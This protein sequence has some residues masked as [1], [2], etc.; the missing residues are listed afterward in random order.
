M[1]RR[2]KLTRVVSIFRSYYRVQAL[3]QLVKNIVVY[4]P[5]AKVKNFLPKLKMYF[6]TLL[7]IRLKEHHKQLN[8]LS[9]IDLNLLK[10]MLAIYLRRVSNRTIKISDR[11]SFKFE[12]IDLNAVLQKQ[13]I[14][15]RDLIAEQKQELQKQAKE[16]LDQERRVLESRIKDN[17]RS[18]QRK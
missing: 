17:Y 12:K 11:S 18:H 15:L 16:I 6:P 3:D 8:P 9:I 4:L 1:Q 14:L 13:S 5:K 7:K 2:R 10:H